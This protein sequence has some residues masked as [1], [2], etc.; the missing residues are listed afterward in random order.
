MVDPESLRLRDAIL[1]I[2]ADDAAGGSEVTKD[3]YR[4]VLREVLKI[5]AKPLIIKNRGFSL[6]AA[7]MHGQNA[8]MDRM[9]IAIRL[10]ITRSESE[11]LAEISA[12]LGE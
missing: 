1:E 4:R 7:Y 6:A 9:I 10:A 12:E 2:L 3:D 8:F 5:E 11:T